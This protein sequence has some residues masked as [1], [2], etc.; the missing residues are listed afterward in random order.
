MQMAHYKLT[1]IILIIVIIIIIILIVII[2]I[3][4]VESIYFLSFSFT[5]S[6]ESSDP[7]FRRRVRKRMEAS[8]RTRR[9]AYDWRPSSTR[10]GKSL[11]IVVVVDVIAVVVVVVVV[12]VVDVDVKNCIICTPRS[13]MN[14]LL[15][16][17]RLYCRVSCTFGS[18]M[19]F[20]RDLRCI[21]SWT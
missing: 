18:V 10:V 8:T 3:I 16:M 2:I 7:C 19:L 12:I 15:L 4:I 14:N 6:G 20:V 5:Q 17:P 21:I 11:P 13:A 9:T 1:I